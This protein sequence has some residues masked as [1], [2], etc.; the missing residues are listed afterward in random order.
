M[1]SWKLAII[2]ASNR[3]VADLFSFPLRSSSLFF[4]LSS[5]AFTIIH[6]IHSHLELGAFILLFTFF[7]LMFVNVQLCLWAGNHIHF[8]DEYLRRFLP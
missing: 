6:T 3:V 1:R 7:S 2:F 5:I 4:Q 8:I